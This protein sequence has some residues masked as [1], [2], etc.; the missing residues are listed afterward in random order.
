M[1]CAHCGF[2]GAVREREPEPGEM[3]AWVKEACEYGIPL[4]I[5]TGGEPFERFECL[6]Q[7]V[8]AAESMGTPAAVFTSSFWAATPE[9]TMALLCRLPGL[10]HLY[11]SSDPFHQRRVPYQ[12]VYNAISAAIQLSIP[13]ISI[14]V[15]YTNDEERRD[16]RRQYEQYGGRLRF[17]EE[18]VIPNPNFSKRVLR[19]QGTLRAPKPEEYRCNCE[20]GTPI[21]NPNGDVFSCHVGK[22]A[23]HRDLRHL[24]YFLGNLHEARFRD[25]MSA[26]AC[27]ADYQ[28]LRTHG[29]QGV[30]RL[31]EE[32]PGLIRAVGRDGFTTECDMCFSVLTSSEGRAALNRHVSRPDV[33]DAI[34]MRLALIFGEDI[35]RGDFTGPLAGTHDGQN[36]DLVQISS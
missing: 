32:E 13:K 24:T 19:E 35:M 1:G 23:A 4:I 10:K 22:A 25:I 8:A 7:G 36:H 30:A 31:F 34:D 28:F 17:C 33:R 26:A 27:R 9:A 20:I 29:A 6:E 21:V 16:V 3:A 15:T 11:L 2:I 14:V 5:F 18:R 12:N